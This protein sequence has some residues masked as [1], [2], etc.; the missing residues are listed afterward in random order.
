MAERLMA[1]EERSQGER[2]RLDKLLA[3][4]TC[5]KAAVRERTLAPGEYRVA[6][7]QED[8]SAIAALEHEIGQVRNSLS[9]LEEDR[10][11]AATGAGREDLDASLARLEAFATK[12]G[13]ELARLQNEA[14]SAVRATAVATRDTWAEYEDIR[15][16]VAQVARKIGLLSHPGMDALGAVLSA[17]HDLPAKL[18]AE[19]FEERLRFAADP[20][21]V[22]FVA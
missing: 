18:V 13:P 11:K 4:L 12:S 10:R 15:R 8:A 7:A 1:V 3:D 20:G 21:E 6:D 19:N 17:V 2:T 14:L 5:R 9:I 16:E 22:A